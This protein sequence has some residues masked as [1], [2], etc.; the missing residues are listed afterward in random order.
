MILPFKM[1]QHILKYHEEWRHKCD[2]CEKKFAELKSLRLH[3]RTHTGS[4][5]SPEL[6]YIEYLSKNLR[7]FLKILRL[8]LIEYKHLL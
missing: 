2:F 3:L 7:Y 5:I 1:G 8:L 6:E 4:K